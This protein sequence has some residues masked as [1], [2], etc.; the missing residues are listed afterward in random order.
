MI[1]DSEDGEAALR[2]EPGR[3]TLSRTPDGV[4]ALRGG[5]VRRGGRTPGLKGGY[6]VWRCPFGSRWTIVREGG[7]WRLTAQPEDG[8]KATE[9]RFSAHPFF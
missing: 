1:F 3:Y 4:Y 6:R 2:F 5:W 9:V 7:G 8:G